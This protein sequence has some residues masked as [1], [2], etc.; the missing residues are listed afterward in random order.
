MKLSMNKRKIIICGAGGHTRSIINL[1]NNQYDVV[2]IYDDSYN[3]KS[4]ENIYGILIR[5]KTKDIPDKANLI[6]SI[7][8]NSLRKKFFLQF[9]N[10]IIKEN[11]IHKTSIIEKNVKLSN[12]NQIFGN[13]YINS[14]TEIGC[15]NIINTGCIIEHEARIGNHNHIS[16]G[17][18]ICGRVKIG[19]ECFI[20][21][22][23]V[24]KDKIEICDNVTIGANSLVIN[25]INEPGVYVG[26]P[27][28]KI[29]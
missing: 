10:R 28:K 20:G 22:G 13:S 9:E 1:I 18:I 29:K 19:D 23:S 8:N 3:P 12:S 21:A 4:K 27:A 11:L 26:S 2:G 16:V 25:N 14:M 24:I 5:G 17:S 15:N 6:L 7:G